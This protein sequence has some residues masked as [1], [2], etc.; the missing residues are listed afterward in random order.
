MKHSHFKL[1]GQWAIVFL[2]LASF[3]AYAEQSQNGST[4]NKDQVNG[5]IEESK[6]TVKEMTGKI[7]DDKGMEIEGNVQKNL[8]KAQAGFGDLKKDIKDDI[9]KDN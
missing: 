3:G 1:T 4:I 6:G 9:N 8:G 2:M 7:M 5:R